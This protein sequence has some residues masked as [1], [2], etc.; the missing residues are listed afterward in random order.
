MTS[1]VARLLSNQGPSSSFQRSGAPGTLAERA[2]TWPIGPATPYA[3]TAT[4]NRSRRG[5]GLRIGEQTA[6]MI[7]L[8]A[9][10]LPGLAAGRSGLGDVAVVDVAGEE[11]DRLRCAAALAAGHR[12]R[13]LGDLLEAVLERRPVL[14]VERLAQLLADPAAALAP[15]AAGERLVPGLDVVQARGEQERERGA[16]EQVVDVAAH[17]LVEPGH[18]VV[19]ERSSARR[20]PGPAPHGSR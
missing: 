1:R 13:H 2:T 3:R 7:R 6:W 11:G 18:L 16:D 12:Q 19:V 20:P 10:G 9:G 4:R 5:I 17:L 8:W 15:R 14:E